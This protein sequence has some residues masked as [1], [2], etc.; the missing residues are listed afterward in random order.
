[1]QACRRQTA[2][3]IWNDME[4]NR[5]LSDTGIAN[6]LAQQRMG[7][8]VAKQ[9]FGRMKNPPTIMTCTLECG[10]GKKSVANFA[11][12]LIIFKFWVAMA[13]LTIITR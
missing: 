10:A 5:L 2:Q 9:T 4:Q 7:A 1:M 13:I 3:A 6:N 12:G 11:F 8:I